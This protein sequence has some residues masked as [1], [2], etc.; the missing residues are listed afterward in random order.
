MKYIKLELSTKTVDEKVAQGNAI[1]AGMTNNPDFPNPSLPLAKF[2]TFINTMAAKMVAR[3]QA[4]EAAKAATAELHAAE[5]AY[6]S[7]VSQL[8]AYAEGV[9]GA[10]VQKLEAAGFALRKTPEP[11][12]GLDMVTDLKLTSNSYGGVLLARWKPLRGAKSYEVQICADPPSETSC[13]PF[14]GSSRNSG[15]DGTPGTTAKG[16]PHF[17]KVGHPTDFPANTSCLLPL[18]LPSLT[19]APLTS[20]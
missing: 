15:E 13:G 17:L 5:R 8:C 19:V 9:A 10:D 2:D 11:I 6:D 14:C 1:R 18:S 12:V 3:D 7:A 4:F 20:S 16:R